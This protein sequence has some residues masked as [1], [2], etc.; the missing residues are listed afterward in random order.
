M[1]RMIGD[2]VEVPTISERGHKSRTTIST[3]VLPE[4]VIALWIASLGAMFSF[5]SLR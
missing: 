2:S 3:V 1:Q 5:R 4:M